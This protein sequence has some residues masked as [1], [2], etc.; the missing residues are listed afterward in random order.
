[1]LDSLFQRLIKVFSS[2]SLQFNKIKSV[3]YLIVDDGS[4][5]KS[6]E[7]IQ[8]YIKADFPAKLYRFTRNFG[9]QNAVSAGLDK[10]TSDVVAVIDADLQ[11][12]PEVILEMLKKWREGFDVVYGV[13]TK[14]KENIFKRSAY[15][16]FYRLLSYFSE[17]DIPLDSGDFSL[18]DKKVVK[19]MCDL[20]EKI[21]YP[22]VIRAWVGFPQTGV[23]YE[24]DARKAGKTK[25][26]L[27]NYY[28]LATDGIASSSIRP[29]RFSQILC[30]LY[31]VILILLILIIAVKYLK[32]FSISGEMRTLSDE[33]ALWFLFS[34]TLVS[35]G[36]FVQAFLLYIISAYIGRGYLETKG[37]PTYII[38]ET[39][40][41]QSFNFNNE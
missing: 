33:M 35:F 12:P 30:V 9:H 31:L 32:Y 29:L 40:E 13:R 21:R 23:T 22:R 8:K 18:I 24:R 39:I 38:M 37:R 25:Y 19:A 28:K 2:E 17:I 36:A 14:R 5:D 3:Q 15:W 26:S 6:S 20:P 7:I 1:M 41:Q 11:D 16:L 4:K 34:F 10:S 27:S